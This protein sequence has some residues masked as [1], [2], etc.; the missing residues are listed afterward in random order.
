MKKTLILFV[1]IVL[2]FIL[3]SAGSGNYYGVEVG[4]QAPNF[5]VSNGVNSV[6]LQ[7]LRGKYVVVTFWS[8]AD[9]DSRIANM[10]YDRVA[11]S[12]QSTIL[13]HVALNF[14]ESPLLWSEIC[15]LDG[16]NAR[17]QFYAHNEA[18]AKLMKAWNQNQGFTSLLIDPHGVVVALN[19]SEKM[20]KK[21]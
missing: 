3:A 19:P 12:K 14:D 15:K 10:R 9:A 4:E 20:L 21:L 11:K 17:S 5:E 18:G 2:L 6:Q 1:G 16:L 7:S 8:S 13:E